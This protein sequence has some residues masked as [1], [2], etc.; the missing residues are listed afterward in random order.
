VDNGFFNR[1]NT[2]ANTVQKTSKYY[3]TEFDLEGFYLNGACIS[4]SNLPE[5][6]AWQTHKDDLRPEV[7]GPLLSGAW[8][9]RPTFHPQMPPVRITIQFVYDH[10]LYIV[11]PGLL[12][13]V[14][15]TSYGM[16]G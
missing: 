5:N 7:Q 8:G 11:C 4:I 14:G 9:G 13:T 10:P 3:T 6:I 2:L 12:V 1:N 15:E 16:W